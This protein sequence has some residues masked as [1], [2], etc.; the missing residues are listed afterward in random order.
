MAK[1]HKADRVQ[2]S[3]R[4]IPAVQP[5]V[6]LCI[7]NI[8]FSTKK[9]VWSGHPLL[10]RDYYTGPAWTLGSGCTREVTT[11]FTQVTTSSGLTIVVYHNLYRSH[12]D[13]KILISLLAMLTTNP[14]SCVSTYQDWTE[15]AYHTLQ[16]VYTLMGGQHRWGLHWPSNAPR[17]QACWLST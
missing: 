14:C 9:S 5:C 15:T 4:S 12:H 8:N 7:G 3:Q 6:V 1:R 2:K 13:L 11:S 17:S 16:R 10:A